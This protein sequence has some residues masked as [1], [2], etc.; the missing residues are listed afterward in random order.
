VIHAWG[1]NVVRLPVHPVAWRAR[2]QSGY[3][4]LLDQALAW[5]TELELHV[6][7]DWHSIGTLRTGLFQHPM[8]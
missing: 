1:A 4:D 6:I 5:A 3:F 7:I 2:G 8:Y